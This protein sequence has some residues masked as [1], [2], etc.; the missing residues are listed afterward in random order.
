MT[1]SLYQKSII[2]QRHCHQKKIHVLVQLQNSSCFKKKNNQNKQT[3]K[4]TNK[5]VDV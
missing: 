3:N 4:Q 5:Q 1:P 2:K